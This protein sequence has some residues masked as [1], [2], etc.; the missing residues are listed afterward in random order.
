MASDGRERALTE[1]DDMLKA[2]GFA[3]IAASPTR[4]EFSV[5]QAERR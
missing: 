1:F 2:C 4:H 3:I 5:I